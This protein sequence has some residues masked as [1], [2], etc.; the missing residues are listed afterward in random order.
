MHTQVS[1]WKYLC[2]FFICFIFLAQNRS[3]LA[4]PRYTRS[5]PP[6]V[7]IATTSSSLSLCRT[8]VTDA[9]KLSNV[10]LSTAS[11]AQ[12]VPI[13]L[14]TN[15]EANSF[16]QS[17]L[18][19]FLISLPLEANKTCSWLV[20]C[21]SKDNFR[22]PQHHQR[23][24]KLYTSLSCHLVVRYGKRIKRSSLRCWIYYATAIFFLPYKSLCATGDKHWPWRNTDST[25][26]CSCRLRY[27]QRQTN[28]IFFWLLSLISVWSSLRSRSNR[29]PFTPPHSNVMTFRFIVIL[30]PIP[31]RKDVT[32]STGSTNGPRHDLKLPTASN[33]YENEPAR[34]NIW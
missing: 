21:F 25:V 13:F 28:Q 10:W 31:S 16:L 30:L 34:R 9:N 24:F 29:L 1:Y 18:S 3:C 33:Q 6:T 26:W 17:L 20:V 14:I 8:S 32:R 12:H 22:R 15:N 5:T 27:Y 2:T 7:R 4:S 19:F 11:K 23:W